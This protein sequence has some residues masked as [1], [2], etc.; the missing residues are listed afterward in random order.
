VGAE[1]DRGDVAHHAV[2]AQRGQLGVGDVTRL[3]DVRLRVGRT[4]AVEHDVRLRRQAAH[5]L[6]HALA[7]HRLLGGR[8]VEVGGHRQQV[9]ARLVVGGE[10][11]DD[12]G[13]VGEAV[14]AVVVAG[15]GQLHHVH[16]GQRLG[17]EALGDAGGGGAP[18]DGERGGVA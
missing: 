18:G 12:V 1:E 6:H 16:V 9:A 14:A 15:A 8:V 2:L 10:Q 3:V 7:E 4:D 13:G 11:P 17:D 5:A